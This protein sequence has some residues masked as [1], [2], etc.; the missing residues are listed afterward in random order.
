MAVRFGNTYG[1]TLASGFVL[2]CAALAGVSFGAHAQSADQ[3]SSAINGEM[4]AHTCAACHGTHGRLGD[5]AFAPLAGMPVPQF[6]QSMVDFREGLRPSTLMGHVA[7]GFS[8]SEIHAM[9]AFFAA[10]QPQEGKQR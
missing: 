2:A 6:V 8:D 7:Q 5:E 10:V 9:A 1:R 4:M 3:R